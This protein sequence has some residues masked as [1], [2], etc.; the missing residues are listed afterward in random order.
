MGIKFTEEQANAKLQEKYPELTIS[1]YENSR[2]LA[3]ITSSTCGHSWLGSLSN[4]TSGVGGYKCRACNPPKNILTFEMAAANLKAKLPDLELVEFT[5]TAATATVKSITCGHTWSNLYRNILSKHSGHIC[6]ICNKA[7][8]SVLTLEEANIRL[9]E[10]D[11]EFV[12]YKGLQVYSEVRSL[13]CGHIWLA[14]L[15]NLTTGNTKPLCPICFPRNSTSTGE[16]EVLEYIKSIYSSWIIENDRKCISPYELDILL[17]ELELA[18]EYNGTYFHSDDKTAV[19]LLTKSNLLYNELG[20]RLI[21][22]FD[23]EWKEH[24]DIIKSRLS[25][26]LSASTKIPARKCVVRILNEFPSSFLR[27]NHLQ[28]SGIITPINYGMYYNNELYAVMTFS[29]PRFATE[30]DYE[31]VRYCSKL[32]T[33]VVGGPS[34]LLK[35]F[36]STYKGSIISYSDKRWS[37]GQLYSKIGFN[38]SHTSPP[39]YRYYKTGYTSLSRYQCQ[40]HLLKDR[41]PLIYSDEKTELEIMREAGYY[42]VSDCGNDVWVL[43]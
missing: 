10:L 22:I 9:Q 16:K 31:L 36:R 11:L 42:K 15:N 41:F 19:P 26:M 30:Y 37:S 34:K 8:N 38:Y 7:S 27:E 2:K 32:N 14:S 6:R 25:S 20:Y 23:H 3:T 13:S 21:H 18:I 43:K 28:G 12:E 39:N 4:I 33:T 40:K 35:H 29:K 1:N 17:P 5:K 24:T